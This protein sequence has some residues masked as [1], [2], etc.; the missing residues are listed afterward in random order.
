MG[1]DFVDTSAPYGVPLVYTVRA[2]LEGNPEG[3][4][5]CR[6]RRCRCSSPTSSRRPRPRVWTRSPRASLVRLIWDPVDAS[7]LAGYLVFRKEGDG[8]PVRLTKDPL[9]DPFFTDE[10]ARQ[11]GRYRYTV[12]AV[13]RT[14]NQSAPS[15]EATAEPF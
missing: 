5:R 1:T 8:E 15:P 4:R 9:T 7:D 6:P 3:R 12:R 2:V 11:G 13:D 10:T 14:G